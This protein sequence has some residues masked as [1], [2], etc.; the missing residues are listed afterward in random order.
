M[1]QGNAYKVLENYKQ[2]IIDALTQNLAESDRI[3]SGRLAQ[4]IDVNVSIMGQSIVMTI[5]MEGYWKYVDKGVNGT[6]INRNSIFSFKKKNLKQG[7]MLDHIK[8]RGNKYAKTLSDIQR[9]RK[10]DKGQV[11]QRKKLM[12]AEKA[13]KSLA[14][15]LGRGLAAHG[16]KPTN[17]A[18]DVVE[19]DL[20]SQLRKALFEA[21][22]RDIEVEIKT[23][24][25]L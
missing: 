21:V 17:F 19:G 9:F 8:Y 25:D 5:K 7:V 14:F 2:I 12:S 13:R 24:L 16:I 3:A 18:T 10:N 23:E 4:S 22:G 11:V 1:P 20:G 6:Q 15:I